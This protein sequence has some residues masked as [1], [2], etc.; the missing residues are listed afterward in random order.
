MKYRFQILLK[1]HFVILL[2]ILAVFF[3]AKGDTHLEESLARKYL[4]RFSVGERPILLYY[5]SYIQGLFLPN[6]SDDMYT[7]YE[8]AFQKFSKRGEYFYNDQAFSAFYSRSQDEDKI[9]FE[10]VPDSKYSPLLELILKGDIGEAC[11]SFSNYDVKKKIVYPTPEDRFPANQNMKNVPVS[12][13]KVFNLGYR[14][15]AILQEEIDLNKVKSSDWKAYFH[16]GKNF[17]EPSVRLIWVTSWDDIAKRWSHLLQNDNLSEVR[18]QMKI[19]S[20]S[21]RFNL[22][23][24]EIWRSNINN[25]MEKNKLVPSVQINN[26]IPYVCDGEIDWGGD[27]KTELKNIENT[28]DI[29][30]PHDILSKRDS[31]ESGT[32]T[33]RLWLPNQRSDGIVGENKFTFSLYGENQVCNIENNGVS[34]FEIRKQSHSFNEQKSQATLSAEDKTK[35]QWRLSLALLE[36]Y[37]SDSNYERFKNRETINGIIDEVCLQHNFSLEELLNTVFP[38]HKEVRDVFI[39][40]VNE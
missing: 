30:F 37:E 15:E 32:A 28:I 9:N 25:F 38:E 40:I 7:G 22:L 21:G 16:N 12:A 1:L 36:Y 2:V 8:Q 10:A 19:I 26:T 4:V 29:T 3:N 27:Y 31:L 18:L 35:I 13:V 11:S 17:K 14:K 33:V 34:V 23:G 39:D 6:L 20:E 24:G 5:K